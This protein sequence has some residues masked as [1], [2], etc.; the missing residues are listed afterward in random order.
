MEAPV[1]LDI[2]FYYFFF[3]QSHFSGNCLKDGHSVEKG[4]AK[5]GY[6]FCEERF[7]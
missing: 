7:V 3:F 5:C 2:A 6:R 1:W 4:G